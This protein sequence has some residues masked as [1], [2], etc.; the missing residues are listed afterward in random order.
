MKKILLQARDFLIHPRHTI[1]LLLQDGKVVDALSIT[2]LAAL[3]S[4]VGAGL[5]SQQ[6]GM[7]PAQTTS[8]IVAQVVRPF[9]IWVVWSAV[10]YSFACIL[11]GRGKYRKL[12]VLFG[13]TMLLNVISGLYM[14]ICVAAGAGSETL[15]AHMRISEGFLETIFWI[16][17]VMLAGMS[18]SEA[19]RLPTWKALLAVLLPV[20]ILV[21]LGAVIILAFGASLAA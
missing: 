6:A 9:F 17:S 15:G 4:G 21:L 7:D 8:G 13:Y 14:L 20:I 19:M 1:P 18:V 3:L 12:L 10:S 5:F 11:G 16:W 2:L